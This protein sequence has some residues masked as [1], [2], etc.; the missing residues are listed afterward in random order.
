MSIQPTLRISP[1]DLNSLMATLEVNVVALSECLVSPGYR[2]ELSG[3]NAPGI[4]YNL[5]GI[6]KA[7]IGAASPI[8]LSPHTLIVVPPNSSFRI[9]V[10]ADRGAGSPLKSVD[11]RQRTAGVGMLRR[12]VAG[13]GDPAIILIC[14]YFRACYGASTELFSTL[15]SP[16]VEQFDSSD[17]LDHKLKSALAELVAQEIGTGAMT[18]ALLK[19]V[20]IALLRRSLTSINSWTERFSMLSDPQIVR[21]FADMAARPGAPHTVQ[22]L[23]QRAALSRSLFMA[24]F[25]ELTGRS[26]M[27]VLRDLRMRQAARQLT[28]GT[29]AV[30]QIARNAGYESR[31][32]F[33]RAFRKAYGCE[34]SDYR[35]SEPADPA[36]AGD[37]TG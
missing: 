32:S 4:H 5:A 19:Q 12:F 17:Q 37:S 33:I 28:A 36:G 7:F 10:S 30:G 8:D 1:S 15:S 13:E 6:G 2:L 21:A 11:G 29:L 34:P 16:I 24:R 9:E 35:C 14:G 3:V 31:S 18:S 27:V 22:S 25:T 23:A 20:I 26:P